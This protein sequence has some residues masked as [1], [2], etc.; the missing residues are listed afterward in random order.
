MAPET[1]PEACVQK[2]VRKPVR[3]NAF[4]R[5]SGVLGPKQT[6]RVRPEGIF[7]V[8]KSRP[9]SNHQS[10]FCARNSFFSVFFA[11]ARSG[12]VPDRFRRLRG[13]S[14][15]GFQEDFL[16]FF[17]GF[18]RDLFQTSPGRAGM[19]PGCTVNLRNLFSGL[20]LGYGDLA[21]RF[22]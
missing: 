22:K 16:A 19:V 11:R 1:M 21:K 7:G 2:V 6:I 15:T 5:R 12:R 13:P 8:P 9:F 17:S 18:R 10:T 14:R 4:F 20:P 3:A